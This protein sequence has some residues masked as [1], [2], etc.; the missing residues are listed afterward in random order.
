MYR[1]AGNFL[2]K[3]DNSDNAAAKGIHGTSDLHVMRKA[4]LWRSS[5]TVVGNFIYTSDE[6]RSDAL[7]LAV[8][9]EVILDQADK[10][11]VTLYADM[12]VELGLVGG[13]GG[14]SAR[15]AT[16]PSN[17]GGHGGVT[18]IDSITLPAGTYSFVVGAGGEGGVEDEGDQSDDTLQ[19]GG[20]GARG[21]GDY[22]GAGYQNGGAGGG[23]T[24]IFLT[25]TV[26]QGNAI[27]IVG[28][29]GGAGSESSVDGSGGAGGPV[30]GTGASAPRL[31]GTGGT[32]GTGGTADAS[33]TGT[34]GSA[35]QGG[36]G[37]DAGFGGGG[38]GGG[39]YGG[40][41]GY[42]AGNNSAGGGG[43][44][45]GYL[46]YTNTDYGSL[47]QYED[48]LTAAAAGSW[49]LASLNF[50]KGGYCPNNDTPGYAG[51]EDSGAGSTA[52]EKSQG[53][54]G[55]IWLKVISIS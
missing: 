1:R 48:G 18:Y 37:G 22:G 16:Y 26:S 27:A 6:G 28:G 33:G 34:N 8:D 25:S 55:V 32:I 50:L 12:T 5:V 52:K 13:G 47:S 41:G 10:Y 11:T 31:P 51:N 7:Q 30:N 36:D 2:G 42:A 15:F 35:L 3:K 53:F 9:E 49:S 54:D 40:G 29:G 4:G 17:F 39:W 45:S 20:P 44:G 43:G 14:G 21:Q 19:Y 24:G 46:D 23:F 38:G